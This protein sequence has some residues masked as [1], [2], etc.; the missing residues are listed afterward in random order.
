MNKKDKVCRKYCTQ[1]KK[2]KKNEKP[3]VTCYINIVLRC[4]KLQPDYR[5]QQIFCVI[6]DLQNCC[7][8]SVI[9]NTQCENM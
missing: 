9:L 2:I 6:P 4:I 1:C 8:H 3:G 7:I 5:L